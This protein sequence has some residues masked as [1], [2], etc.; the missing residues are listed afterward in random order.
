M[1]GLSKLSTAKL[2]LALVGILT[3][4]A[5]IRWQNTSVR[6]AGIALVAVAWFLRF[7]APRAQS[8]ATQDT[9]LPDDTK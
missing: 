8:P 5:G 2:V 7:A 9:Q 4:G 6:W 3:F 1:G